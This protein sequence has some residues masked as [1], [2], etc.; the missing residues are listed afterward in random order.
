MISAGKTNPA[1][2]S[3]EAFVIAIAHVCQT[4]TDQVTGRGVVFIELL[5]THWRGV[6][7]D[8]PGRKF[9]RNTKGASLGPEIFFTD[10]RGRYDQRQTSRADVAR[11]AFERRQT[12]PTPPA[13]LCAK[14]FG[15]EWQ[16]GR[17]RLFS[18]RI[19]AAIGR[20]SA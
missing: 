3:G 5:I 9:K 19:G 13:G 7:D 10:V 8:R 14:Q 6:D 11:V 20:K 2:I 1:Q 15:A 4:H 12:L 16:A 18:S 17:T